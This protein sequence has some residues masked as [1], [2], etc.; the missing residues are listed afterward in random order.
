MT[1]GILQCGPTPA[2]LEERFGA[3]GA[4]VG[5]MLGPDTPTIIY[6]V[7]SGAL[8]TDAHECTGYIVTGS[9]AGVHDDLPWIAPLLAFL[10]SARGKTRL[11]GIC[12][13]HQA[14]AQAFGGAV[15][16][17]RAGWGIGVHSYEVAGSAPF[18]DAERGSRLSSPVYHQD[19]VTR[20][21]ADARVI[22]TSAFTPFAALDYGDAV[23]VQCHP[24]FEPG[25]GPAL[26]EARRERHGAATDIAIA[27]YEQAHNGVMIGRWLSRF[28]TALSP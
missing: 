5:R 18:L 26:L 10:R 3:Y 27:S 14:L 21:P 23:S 28:L 20:A 6:D 17:S 9:P 13:G 8:P 19:Q 11:V 16:R 22:L 15:S 24:E 2:G 4:M 25:F 1:I 7:A 12:F